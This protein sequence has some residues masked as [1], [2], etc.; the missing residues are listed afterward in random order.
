MLSRLV[1]RGCLV[2]EEPATYGFHS[3]FHSDFDFDGTNS[4]QG[5][6]VDADKPCE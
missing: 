1:R 5:A 2:Q 4:E 3:D 6:A